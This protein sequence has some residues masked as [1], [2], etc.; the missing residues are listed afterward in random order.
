MRRVLTPW[1]VA[2][3]LATAMLMCV[4][5]E[6]LL[7][8]VQ[9]INHL[10]W[11]DFEW[12]PPL[13]K[14]TGI[15]SYHG[16]RLLLPGVDGIPRGLS[17]ILAGVML[18]GMLWQAARGTAAV[19]GGLL[20]GMAWIVIVYWVFDLTAGYGW[21]WNIVIND[22]LLANLVIAAV[23]M[24]AMLYWGFGPGSVRSHN[25]KPDNHAQGTT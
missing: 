18:T 3:Y 8:G 13:A 6:A 15:D 24:F 23:A 2:P 22:L 20:G 9:H 19:Y 4:L 1:Q 21:W 5:S 16:P 10:A 7:I 11:S 17:Y 25:A 12:P 14:Y